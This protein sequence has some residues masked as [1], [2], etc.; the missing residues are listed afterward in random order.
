MLKPLNPKPA[1]KG[2][3]GSVHPGPPGPSGDPGPHGPQVDRIRP[4]QILG[5]L[6]TFGACFF[7]GSSFRPQRISEASKSDFSQKICGE[8]SQVSDVG[9]KSGCGS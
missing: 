1:R 8:L 6:R 9:F 2:P 7:A 5:W 4:E 3:P